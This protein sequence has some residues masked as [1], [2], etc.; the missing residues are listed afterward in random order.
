MAKIVAAA[1]LQKVKRGRKAVID[2]TLVATLA[3]LKKDQAVTLEDEFGVVEKGRR[4]TVSA[5]IRRHWAEGRK[6][7]ASVTYSPEG[8]AQVEVAG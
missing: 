2:S 1:S 5:I 3:S 8:I 4:S 6:D 7:K